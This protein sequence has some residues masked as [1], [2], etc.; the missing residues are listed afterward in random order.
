MELGNIAAQFVIDGSVESVAP[1]GEGLI[2]DTYLVRTAGATPDYILQRK[3]KTIFKDVPGMMD[4][5]SRVSA[6][7]AR[8]VFE[9]GG[10][11]MR[12]SLTVVPALDNMLYHVDAAGDYWA[13]CVYIPDT[14]TYDKADSPALAEKGGAAI[15]K[16][17]TQL[18]DFREPLVDTL[19]GF[20]NMRFRFEQWD[21]VVKADRVGRV[22]EVREEMGW[23][24]DRRTKMMDFWA[25]VETGELPMRVTHNDT[26]IS[27]VL[28]DQAGN[29]LCVIDLDTVLSACGLN[30][31]GDAIRSYANHGLEDDANLD[32]VYLD[33][34]IFAAF[35]RGYLSEARAFLTPTERKWLAFSALFITFEQTLRFL[36]DY[37]D[38]D[39]Y[40]KVRDARHN[41]V[42]TH[43]QYKLLRSM[44]EHLPRMN[45]LVEEF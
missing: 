42:R 40:Y 3:N 33:W 9:A 7:V 29:A 24:A 28:F 20:H 10:D 39:R 21:A 43:A 41:L 16:F 13:M 30:D 2:N 26:K 6:H 27:N 5:I 15:G 31:Y 17:Q 32:N 25:M 22:A 36:M 14:V 38:G 19:P 4:N 11:P 45:R 12:E 34:D 37:I 1:V 23:I 18:A 44:E 8:K 35:T